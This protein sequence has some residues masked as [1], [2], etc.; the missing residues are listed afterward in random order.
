MRSDLR[1]GRGTENVLFNLLRYAPEIMDIT[2]VESDNLKQTRI[3]EQEIKKITSRF[4]VIK[5]HKHQY[6]LDSLLQRIYVNTILRPYYR[7]LEW[8]KSNGLLEEIRKTD[9]VYLFANEYSIF[10]K[11]MNIPIIGSGHAFTISD[12]VN[13]QDLPHKLY[14]NYLYKTYFK[15]INGFNYFPK[16]EST[17]NKFKDMWNLKYNFPLSPG[18][19]TELFYPDN[20][21]IDQKI[22]LLFVASLEYNKGLDILIPLIKKFSNNDEIEFHIA[23]TGPV[24]EELK[25]IKTLNFYG[26]LSNEE[27][28]KLY[29]ECDIFVYPSHNDTYSLVIMQAL[30]SGLYVLTGDFFKGIFDDF[31]KYLEYI[32]MNVESFY[33]RINEIIEDKNIIEHNKQEEYEYTKN[34]YDWS[35]IAKKFYDNMENIYNEFYHK[36]NRKDNLKN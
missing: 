36:Q 35:I 10:F 6:R 22:R 3:S 31:T 2:I 11:G 21:K 29:R 5:I 1:T 15:G 24:E 14:A 27:L 28:A 30:S 17:F 16:D 34:N 26:R 12:F 18:V 25:E 23:G 9:M 13:R 8:A 20:H 19:D 7:D 32:P 4:N 33:G